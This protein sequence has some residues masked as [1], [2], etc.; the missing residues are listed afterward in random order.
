[1]F[2]ENVVPHPGNI[3]L[4]KKNFS[5][6]GE[7][8]SEVWSKTVIND[9]KV[10]CKS[11]PIGCQFI[12][13]DPDQDFVSRH[14]MQTRYGIQIVKCINPNCCEPFKTNWMSIIKSQFLP[15]PA[16]HEFTSTG[17]RAVEPS[18]YL[19]NPKNYTFARLKQRIISNFLPNEAE[20]FIRPPYDLYCPS[21][22]DKLEKCICTTCGKYWPSEAAKKR[23]QKC[24]KKSKNNGPEAEDLIPPYEV[25]DE[26]CMLQDEHVQGNVDRIQVVENIKE[27]IASPFEIITREIEDDIM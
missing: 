15:P 21:M 22:Q 13:D 2:L 17:L 9:F 6:A 7:A 11:M 1:M 5:A 18:V 12:P 4:E 27:F 25:S 23:H 26:F 10:D 14:V 24:H 3:E 16:I 19:S 8:L 20:N